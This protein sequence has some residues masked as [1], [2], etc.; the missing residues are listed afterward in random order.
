MANQN[1]IISPVMCVMWLN[2]CKKEFLKDFYV[3]R[4]HSASFDQRVFF[5]TDIS[6]FLNLVCKLH[7][8]YFWEKPQTNQGS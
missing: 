2:W 5:R 1:L 3:L 4:L 8:K 7:G 6:Y